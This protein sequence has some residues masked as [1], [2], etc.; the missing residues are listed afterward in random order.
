MLPGLGFPSVHD[1]C[2]EAIWYESEGFNRFRGDEWMKEPCRSCPEKAKDF[3]GCR[4]QA[5]L[6]TGDPAG[7]DPVCDLSPRHDRVMA[8]VAQAHAGN[9]V[10]KPMVFR[11][12]RN[13]RALAG[14]RPSSA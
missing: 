2:L 3:G 13:S 12:N 6:L 14:E 10:A 1:A 4:W 11:S 8:A 7:A 9:V 5:Y